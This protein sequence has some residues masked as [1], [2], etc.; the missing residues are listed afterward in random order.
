[1]KPIIITKDNEIPERLYETEEF[2]RDIDEIHET[3]SKFAKK[4]KDNFCGVQTMF[5]NNTWEIR[6]IM[7]GK[8]IQNRKSP[9]LNSEGR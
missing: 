7:T 4:Y 2:I 8:P 9:T 1:M 3:L 6:L 5:L